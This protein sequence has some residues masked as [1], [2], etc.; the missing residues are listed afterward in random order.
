VVGDD[1]WM[2]PPVKWSTVKPR[3]KDTIGATIK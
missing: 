2:R 3:Y 1:C